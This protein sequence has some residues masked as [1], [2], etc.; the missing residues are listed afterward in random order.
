MKPD[1]QFTF[2]GPNMLP[3]LKNLED[4]VKDFTS[5]CM[6][7]GDSFATAKAKADEIVAKI[8]GNLVMSSRREG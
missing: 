8:K 3:Q 4:R 7:A 6:L 2:A 5:L 1:F